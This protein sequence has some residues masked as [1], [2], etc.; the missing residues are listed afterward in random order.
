[1]T[2]KPSIFPAN[3]VSVSSLIYTPLWA[4]PALLSEILEPNCI[5][6]DAAIK[7]VPAGIV[8]PP[9]DSDTV[10]SAPYLINWANLIFVIVPDGILVVAPEEPVA[11]Q[12]FF[13]S[14]KSLIEINNYF[15][16]PYH[17]LL[18]LLNFTNYN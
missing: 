1:M 18:T 13:C 11:Q 10:I 15:Y 3:S 5:Y 7:Y 12:Y 9:V 17:K 6:T 14:S 4:L 2:Y 8:T 16:F